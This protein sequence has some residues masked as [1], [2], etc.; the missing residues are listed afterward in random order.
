MA[1]TL[2]IKEVAKAAGTT[3]RTLR[4]YDAIGLLRPTDIADNGYRLYDTNALI[5]LQRILALRDLGMSLPQ[6]QAV[7]LRDIPETHAL[8]EL[9]QQ[10]VKESARLSRQIASVRRTLETIK[11]GETPM[12]NDIFDGFD[13][14]Q[15]KDEV[16]ERWGA[17]T[18]KRSNDWWNSLGEEG[19]KAYQ[20]K[21]ADLTISWK[22]AHSD[23]VAPES[24]TAQ[25]L[26][27]QQVDWLRDTPGPHTSG[28]CSLQTY[29]RNLGEMYINDPRFAANYGGV[30]AATLVRDSL[31]VYVDNN[32]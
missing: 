22:N 8:A 19:Q 9:E 6:I 20:Q 31:N 26:A 14:N 21:L 23:G 24:D 30:E 1:R 32:L 12:P 5:R 2:T 17:D 27:K 25:E 11:K 13:H 7:L 28:E 29:V 10:L 18:F 4:H 15:Y 16:E 3:S